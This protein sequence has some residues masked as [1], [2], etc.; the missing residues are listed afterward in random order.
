MA[1]CLTHVDRMDYD[2]V[3]VFEG[4]KVVEFDSPQ[5]RQ[6]STDFH[7]AEW[8]GVMAGAVE[9]AVQVSGFGKGGRG[10]D[11]LSRMS[12]MTRLT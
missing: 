6:K 3:A 8:L 2:K 7:M 5:A 9:A 10:A 12:R 4:G 1:E 11:S